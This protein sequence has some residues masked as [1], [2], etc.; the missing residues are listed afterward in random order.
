MNGNPPKALSSRSMAKQLQ[1]KWGTQYLPRS[2]DIENVLPREYRGDNRHLDN[3]PQQ[4]EER[5]NQA[6]ERSNFGS[7][8]QTI[9]Y[10]Q[11]PHQQQYNLANQNN[12]KQYHQPAVNQLYQPL[13]QPIYQY[14][15][16]YLPPVRTHP[17]LPGNF[18]SN[19]QNHLAPHQS[20][21]TF[22]S[23]NHVNWRL[24]S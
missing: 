8:H 20:I 9:P 4:P 11:I 16:I 12:L 14:P 17:S 6:N 22:Q 3:D 18:Q 21:P 24:G 23:R 5:I 13:P 15:Q 10:N 19:L 7:R 1:E 2:R